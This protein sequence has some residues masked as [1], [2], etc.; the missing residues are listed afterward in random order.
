VAR[1]VHLTRLTGVAGNLLADRVQGLEVDRI[2]PTASGG[3]EGY[4][5]WQL[6]HGHCHEEKATEDRRRYVEQTP[7]Y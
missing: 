7:D 1:G 6:L 3:K 5:N 2:I 4:D